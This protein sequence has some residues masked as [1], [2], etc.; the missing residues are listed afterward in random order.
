MNEIEEALETVAELL[1]SGELTI[2]Q[3]NEVLTDEKWDELFKAINVLLRAI[4]KARITSQGQRAWK[5][6]VDF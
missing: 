1:P 4:E 3:W 2:E 6:G 5:T